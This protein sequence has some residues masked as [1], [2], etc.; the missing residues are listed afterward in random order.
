M[1]EHGIITRI[2][3]E[4]F[5]DLQPDF[6]ILLTEKPEII[7]E[8]RFKRDNID[9]DIQLIHSFQTEEK[10]YAEEIAS[11]LGVPLVISKGA[12]DLNRLTMLLQKWIKEM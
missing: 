5:F 12:N 4:T 11:T 9:I 7:A 8:R 10:L 3:L 6:I 2:S 1:N